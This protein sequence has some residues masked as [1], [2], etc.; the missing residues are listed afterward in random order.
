MRSNQTV[1]PSIAT[2]PLQRPKPITYLNILEHFESCPRFFLAPE[3][4]QHNLGTFRTDRARD[5][6]MYTTG[7]HSLKTLTYSAT[8]VILASVWHDETAVYF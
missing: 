5:V 8:N 2:K 4:T 3:M 1:H 7:M 6:I